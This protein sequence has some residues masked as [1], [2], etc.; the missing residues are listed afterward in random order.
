MPREVVQEHYAW[1]DPGP[2]YAYSL[3][4]AT[5]GGDGL[6]L[7]DDKIWAPSVCYPPYMQ[8]M[9][10]TLP[11]YGRRALGRSGVEVIRV[12]G[13]CATAYNPNAGNYGHFILE[14]LPRIFLLSILRRKD[15]D[16]KIAVDE[17]SPHWV[18]S[19]YRLFFPESD[20]LWFNPDRQV[21]KPENVIMTTTMSNINSL[22]LGFSEMI[23]NLQAMV[24]IIPDTAKSGRVYFSR[25]KLLSPG[26]HRIENESEIESIF[27][28]FG[29]TIA[30]PET[31]SPRGQIELCANAAVIAGEFGSAIHNSIFAPEETKVFSLNRINWFQSMICRLR[32]QRLAYLTPIGGM[33]DWRSIEAGFQAMVVDT[34]V[35]RKAL[36]GFV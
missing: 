35:L 18:R 7:W 13:L 28:D 3:P 26:R 1:A 27:Q 32:R 23:C 33:R 15:V 22:G 24:G 29:F 34:G 6:V 11:S 4:Y 5:I 25:T 10:S 8:V 14:V 2:G 31:M 30:Y 12:N 21:V 19:F 16:F 17:G 36:L 9:L 20:I